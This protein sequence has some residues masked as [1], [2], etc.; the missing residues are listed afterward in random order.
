M[1]DYFIYQNLVQITEFNSVARGC[2]R[3]RLKRLS[4][5][6]VYKYKTR[7]VV[8]QVSRYNVQETSFNISDGAS[9]ITFLRI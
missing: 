6:N 7:S 4:T 3:V 2:V 1:Y 8:S 5:K 9:D